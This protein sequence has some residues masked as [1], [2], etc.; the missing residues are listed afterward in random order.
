MSKDLPRAEHREMD[1]REVLAKEFFDVTQ[2][3][4]TPFVSDE[5]TWYD[6]DYLR[7]RRAS[8]DNTVSLWGSARRNQ[9]IAALLGVARLLGCNPD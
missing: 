3:E 9:A 5:A 8:P 1:R 2:A 6:F 7:I 4:L